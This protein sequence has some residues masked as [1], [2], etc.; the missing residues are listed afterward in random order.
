M[1]PSVNSQ[2]ALLLECLFTELTLVPLHLQ[3]T[4]VRDQRLLGKELFI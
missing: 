4:D 1:R 2:F 3:R